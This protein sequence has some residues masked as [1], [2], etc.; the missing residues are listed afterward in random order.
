MSK[1]VMIP[2]IGANPYVVELNGVRYSYPAGT[3]QT[4]PDAVAAIIANDITLRPQEDPNAGADTPAA[5]KAAL[6]ALTARVAALEEGGGAGGGNVE[7][8]PFEM[9]IGEMGAVT[10]TTDADFDDAVK[11]QADGKI[12][13]ADVIRGE[14]G[15]NQHVA[16]ILCGYHKADGTADNDAIIEG[17]VPVESRGNIVVYRIK[18]VPSALTLTPYVLQPVEG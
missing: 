16:G 6:D 9:E 10:L 1:T 15:Y 7:V 13:I 17:C 11:A 4:V 18:W 12:L 2:T 3:E 5:I 14:S 8:I